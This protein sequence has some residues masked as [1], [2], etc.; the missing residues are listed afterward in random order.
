MLTHSVPTFSLGLLAEKLYLVGENERCQINTGNLPEII[1]HPLTVDTSQ[2]SDLHRVAV[3]L[4]L[5]LLLLTHGDKVLGHVAHV[6][7]AGGVLEHV[8]PDGRVIDYRSDY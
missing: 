6:H 7:H 2:L 4:H 8:V 1:D 5:G 3:I